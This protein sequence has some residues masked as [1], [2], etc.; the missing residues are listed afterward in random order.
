MYTIEVAVP[1]PLATNFTYLSKSLVKEGCRVRVP[2]GTAKIIGVCLGEAK[3]KDLG[4]IELKEIIEVLDEKPILSPTLLRLADWI[5]QYYLHP[6]GEV[7]KTMLPTAQTKKKEEYYELLRQSFIPSELLSYLFKK[8]K[9]SSATL[10]KRLKDWK[11][12]NPNSDE[13]FESYIKDGSVL[14]SKNIQ[15]LAKQ[16]QIHEKKKSQ[17]P[18][19]SP[20]PL[21][22][23]QE[24]VCTSIAESIDKVRCYLLHGVTGSGKTRVYMEALRK[25]FAHYGENAQAL[26]L[27]PEIA[28]TPQMTHV[29]EECFPNQ[30]AVVHSAMSNSQRWS[31]LSQIREGKA[32]I[33][34]GPRS[35]VF[36]SFQNLKLII[37]DEEHDSSYKQSSGLSYNGR[38]LAVV[39]SRMEGASCI[40]GSA[41]PSI[42]SYSNAK[43][44]KY[45]VLELK[46]RVVEQELPS[47]KVVPAFA[48]VSKEILT[49]GQT[50]ES[51]DTFL[52]P[53][54]LEALKENL[55]R[56]QQA[57][58]LVNRRGYAYYLLN[59]ETKEPIECPS[60]S[61]SLTVH[62]NRT[63]LVCHYCGFQS[64]IADLLS[65]HPKTV[66]SA[67]GV[68]SQKAE[69]CLQRLLPE[70][71][72]ARLDSD[73]LTS[74]EKLFPLLSAF[75][76]GDIDILVGTQIV[77]KG[78]DFPN[79]GLTVICELDQ[80]LDLPDFRAGERA[81]Q[82]IVQAAGRA[83]RS[84]KGGKVLIQSSK[85]KDP[86]LQYALN[87]DFLG[88]AEHEL[89]VRK[90][91]GYPPFQP[92]IRIEITST[93]ADKLEE[94]CSEVE[95][96]QKAYVS[97]IA[98]DKIR[99]LGPV[100]PPIERINK[101]FRRTILFSSVNLVSVHRLAY[102]FLSSFP[103]RKGDLRIQVDVDPQSL[104]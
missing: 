17:I 3:G 60:C 31:E 52:S 41:T 97:K 59:T 24:R 15:D 49:S 65:L 67:V 50:H 99:I 14:H 30:I 88:F 72:V 75:R 98:F 12:Q 25:F 34:I 33:L 85:E 26:V 44:S 68:G 11:S 21:N 87:H 101:R 89:A 91:Y 28:L 53:E 35:A 56:G 8:K 102:E 62:K 100:V 103:L 94:F 69:A 36:A 74:R 55:Q 23:E 2:F 96:W 18:E 80:M 51:E 77:A 64:S 57:I 9:I 71:K 83:G 92:M 7:L 76:K 45:Q 70:A 84:S 10:K 20:P 4:G 95:Q 13:N 73:I 27:V 6:L 16:S 22:K 78:H 48:S 79:V 39:R 43:Q 61:I 58:V 29:F 32:R 1:V 86:V 54:T 46:N 104:M 5:S 40:L 66:F 47:I 82:L 19:K 42:E 81:F 63:K 37:V 93:E 90:S 38:D